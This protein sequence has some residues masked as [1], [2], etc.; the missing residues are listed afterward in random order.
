M[1]YT[2][3]IPK[4]VFKE[5]GID[6][7]ER[8]Q[9][10][11]VRAGKKNVDHEIPAWSNAVSYILSAK[12]IERA[13]ESHAKALKQSAEASEKHARSLKNATWTLVAA[14]VVLAIFTAVSVIN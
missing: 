6:I 2:D 4:E 12:I 9:N 8:L 14:T 1:D 3:Q 5:L 7:G 13:L 10:F 11:L